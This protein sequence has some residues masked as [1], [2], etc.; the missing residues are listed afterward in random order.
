MSS[1]DLVLYAPIALAPSSSSPQI[2]PP[3]VAVAD[4]NTSRSVTRRRRTT[5]SS[6]SA[7]A[8]KDRHTKVCGR[9]R[10]IRLPSLVAARLFQLTRELNHRTDG[11]T[12]EWLLRQA[13]PSIVAAT[14]SGINLTQEMPHEVP[15]QPHVFFPYFT[16]MLMQQGPAVTVAEEGN[17]RDG[18]N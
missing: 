2:L 3:P 14:G 4:A 9:G 8:S 1:S 10:R 5:A 17:D 11:E 6:A 12:I 18:K 15:P 7:S 13:E 16:S